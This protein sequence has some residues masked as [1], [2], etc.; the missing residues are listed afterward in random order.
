MA[1]VFH[2]SSNTIAKFTIYAAAFV[3][4]ALSWTCVSLERSS[5]NTGQHVARPQ[6]VPFSHEHHSAGLGIDCRYCHATVES[7]GF[8]GM[9]PTETCMGCHKIIWDDSPLLAPV[10]ESWRTKS[11]IRWQ[12]VYDLADFVY[13]DHGIHVA[14]GVGCAT[15]HGRIDRMPLTVQAT[16]LTMEW[17]LDCHERPQDFL[18]PR[19]EV[20]DMDYHVSG[21]QAA[22]GARLVQEYDVRDA[23]SLTR[24]SVC[25]R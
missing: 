4:A 18:R 11:P 19:S 6:P 15:C 8:A 9:P 16:P 22:L 13:F 21:D 23:Y 12:R 25:H 10:R 24:C 17:C 14:K 3:I 2:P 20:F 7:A 1:Q 5:Y